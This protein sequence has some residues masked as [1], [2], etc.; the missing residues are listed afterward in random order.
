MTTSD[1]IVI[2][3]A[4]GVFSA[5]ASAAFIGWLEWVGKMVDLTDE[6][7]WS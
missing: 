6:D 5:L 3:I 7:D 1:Y 4:V 2:G